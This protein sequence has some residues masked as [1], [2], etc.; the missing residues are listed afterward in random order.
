MGL[1]NAAV[2]V[3]QNQQ[4]YRLAARARAEALFDVNT[5]VEKYLKRASGLKPLKEYFLS[6]PINFPGVNNV[7]IRNSRKI[8]GPGGSK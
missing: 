8:V 5:M 2:E 3:I 7:G 6:S 1:A 4:K